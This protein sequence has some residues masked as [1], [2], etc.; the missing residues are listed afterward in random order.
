MERTTCGACIEEF[1]LAA[2]GEIPRKMS[3]IHEIRFIQDNLS[4]FR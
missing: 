2:S 4:R 3:N 1:N